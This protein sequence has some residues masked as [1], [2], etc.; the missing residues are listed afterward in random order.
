M[1]FAIGNLAVAVALLLAGGKGA[2]AYDCEVSQCFE[3]RG[4]NLPIDQTSPF[5]YGDNMALGYEGGVTQVCRCYKDGC[6][7]FK[8]RCTDRGWRVYT[9]G[10][11]NCSGISAC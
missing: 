1:K 8:S 5:C 11:C 6:N 7:A 4:G 2:L 9:L 3:D 10:G